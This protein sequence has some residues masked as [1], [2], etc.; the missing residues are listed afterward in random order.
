MF[1]RVIQEDQYMPA[2]PQQGRMI[3]TFDYNNKGRITDVSDF[4]NEPSSFSYDDANLTKTVTEGQ[5]NHVLEYDAKGQVTKKTLSTGQTEEYMYDSAGRLISIVARNSGG[6]QI[7]SQVY[8]Y[9]NADQLTNE[10]STGN[11]GSYNSTFG[12]TAGS[13]TAVSAVSASLRFAS[14][15]ETS[16]QLRRRES[17]TKFGGRFLSRRRGQVKRA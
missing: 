7:G 12:Y 4:Q 6:T 5:R 3:A 16:G 11:Y 9:D 17:S 1:G 14:T 10:L 13:G 2:W 8:S 15:A